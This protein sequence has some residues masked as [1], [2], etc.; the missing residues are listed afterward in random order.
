M[1][2]QFMMQNDYGEMFDLMD[3]EKGCIFAE[4]Q[5]LGI[6]YNIEFYKIGTVYIKN[7]KELVQSSISGKLYFKNYKKYQDL[8]EYIK[9]SNNIRLVYKIPIEDTYDEYYKEIIIQEITKTELSTNKFLISDINMKGLSNWRKEEKIIQLN[10]L[11]NG[12]RI[13]WNF[14]WNSKFG[15]ERNKYLYNN[16]SNLDASFVIE[17]AGE[18]INPIIE[19]RDDQ[20]NIINKVK[21]VGSVAANERLIYSTVDNDLCFKK[22][23]DEAEINLFQTLDLNGLNF[24]KLKKGIN[25][26]KVTANN[27]IKEIIIKVYPEEETV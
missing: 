2:R 4:P 12:R 24:N 18:L 21:Y 14:R 23:N 15:A 6:S 26:I 22:I 9:R 13:K 7:N 5:G 1:V 8:R 11:I 25:K 27:E 16:T 19:I 17:L 3:V 20:D 10:K